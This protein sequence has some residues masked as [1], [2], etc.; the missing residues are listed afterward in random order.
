MPHRSVARWLGP[1]VLVGAVAV[2]VWVTHSTLSDGGSSSTTRTVDP[3]ASA[4]ATHDRT[5]PT[6][7]TPS[8]HQSRTY[9]VQAGDYLTTV[10]SKTGVSIDR[11]REL[12]PG[13][14]ANALQIGQKIRLAGPPP[15]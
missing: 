7:S 1:L 8:S 12:N 4:S 5:P 10:S 15:R 6:T 3:P 13:L 11:L 9:T 2:V 14:D